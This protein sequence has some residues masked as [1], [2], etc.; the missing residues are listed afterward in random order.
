MDTV[1]AFYNSDMS[2]PDAAAQMA[3]SVQSAK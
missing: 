3:K 2:A 1:T